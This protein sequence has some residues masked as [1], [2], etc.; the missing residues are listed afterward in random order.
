[1]SDVVNKA[2]GRKF[3]MALICLASATSL[4]LYGHIS[5]GVYTAVVIATVGAFI[6]GNVVQKAIAAPSK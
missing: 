3:L 5:D 1:M 2:G 6:T 4:C